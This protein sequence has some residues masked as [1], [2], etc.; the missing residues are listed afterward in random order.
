M[1][2]LCKGGQTSSFDYKC[3]PNDDSGDP[4]NEEMCSFYVS[5]GTVSEVF[6]NMEACDIAARSTRNG[7][8]GGRAGAGGAGGSSSGDG[9]ST[10]GGSSGSS[11]D[12]EINCPFG[13]TST[14]PIP[15]GGCEKEYERYADAFGCN[16][17]DLFYETCLAKNSCTGEDTSTCEMYANL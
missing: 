8:G 3:V 13:M 2:V 12:Y 15:V 1:G 4:T 5:G 7:S 6:E 14:V 16:L 17:T 9:S 11:Y 10:G